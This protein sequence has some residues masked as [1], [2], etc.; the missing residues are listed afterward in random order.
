MLIPEMSALMP[1]TPLLMNLGPIYTIPAKIVGLALTTIEADE[2]NW[3]KWHNT[4][5]EK[6]QAFFKDE[7]IEEDIPF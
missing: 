4:Y 5:F 3:V 1:A 6:C 7:K 2:A